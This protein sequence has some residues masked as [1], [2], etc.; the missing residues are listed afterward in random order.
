MPGPA[1]ATQD[2][3][4]RA[5]RAE[6]EAAVTRANAISIEM[7]IAAAKARHEAAMAELTGS[8]SW[9][10]TAPLR[11]FRAFRSGRIPADSAPAPA[12]AHAAAD[13]TGESQSV[14]GRR[15]G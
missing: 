14:M 3:K 4:Y 7:K 13:I 6:A 8:L 12:H 11:R 15:V 1:I 10:L 5:R 9:R 2:W